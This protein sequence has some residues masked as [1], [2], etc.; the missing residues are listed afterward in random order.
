MA[1]NGKNP[2]LLYGYGGFEI[3]MLPSYSPGVGFAWLER[4]VCMCS[5]T[6]AA[7]ASSGRN[8]TRRPGSKPA[9]GL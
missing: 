8:G 9:T 4:G 6:S 5:P 1:L 3:S 7:A 2:T